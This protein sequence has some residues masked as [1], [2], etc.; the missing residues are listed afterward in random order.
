M[1]IDPPKKMCIPYIIDILKKYTDDKKTLTQKEILQKL[2]DK[3]DLIID[4]KT[5]SRNLKDAMYYDERIHCKI[6]K[7]NGELLSED[8]DDEGAIYT[9]Y[10]Y[11]QLFENGELDA[12]IYNIAFS[13][14][15]KPKYKKNIIEKLE[16]LG[17]VSINRKNLKHYV[18]NEKEYTKEF[19][20]LFCNLED[21]DKAIETKKVVE[22]KYACYDE[23]MKLYVNKRVWKV[24]PLGIAEQNND[25]YLIGLTCG[26]ESETPE[27]LIEDVKKQINN[28]EQRSRWLDTFR[29]DRIRNLRV[30]ENEQLN[31][32]D[33]KIAKEMSIKT[34]NYGI[35][36][37]LDYVRQNSTLSSGRIIKAKFKMVNE[38]N[39]ISEAIDFFGKQNIRMKVE[40]SN[41]I[42]TVNTNDRA[43]IEFAKMH[44][45]E[46]EILEPQY[47]RDEMAD[48]LKSAYDR[49]IG[50][51]N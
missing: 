47:L 25:Y 27:E 49:M 24:F 8:E 5:L 20:G 22:F 9:D 43:M 2:K 42:F 18:S 33:K 7:R 34:I 12:L 38:E 14:H 48:M 3:Y 44:L 26:S 35:D 39:G 11:E 13:K 19:A 4:R 30:T 21:L 31:D 51:S 15:I 28:V 6:L 16:T 46:V 50:E 45:T 23:D 41:Y 37:I 29:V 32:V 36:N 40:K 10:Y 1:F 17:P